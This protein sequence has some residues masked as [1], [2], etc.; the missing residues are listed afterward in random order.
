MLKILCKYT[1]PIHNS[2]K[3]RR[4]TRIPASHSH[5]RER[6]GW[7]RNPKVL[8]SSSRIINLMPESVEKPQGISFNSIS[9]LI[10][11]P[12]VVG[13][14]PVLYTECCVPEARLSISRVLRLWLR[15][16]EINTQH[17]YSITDAKKFQTM[18]HLVCKMI[19]KK[20][21]RL[22]SY[23]LAR[24]SIFPPSPM[25]IYTGADWSL[26]GEQSPLIIL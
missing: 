3:I 11:M 21:T 25:V 13:V 18:L 4:D 20:E 8:S 15:Q 12:T 1:L 5:D 22:V 24:P 6:E 2:Y 7:I 16:A 17:S 23:L 9:I 26:T 19:G 10:P 14:C